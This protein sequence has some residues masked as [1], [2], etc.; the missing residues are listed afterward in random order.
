MLQ[1]AM[2]ASHTMER[3]DT[4]GRIARGYA[5]RSVW[6]LDPAWLVLGVLV[7]LYLS[8]LAFDFRA[9]VPVA[10]IP[11]PLYGWGLVLLVA[12][13]GGAAFG[14]NVNDSPDLQRPTPWREA[15]E[16][17]GWAMLLL[18]VATL[19]GYA[20][21]FYPLLERPY[22]I[23]DVA[24]AGGSVRGELT[25]TP[26]ITSL[27]QCGIAFA[28]G[29]AIRR[30][31]GLRRSAWWEW[32][33]LSV[34]L[35]FALLRTFVWNERLALI[36]LVGAF[37]VAYAAFH[38]FRTAT[39]Y[40][41]ASVVPLLAPLI[42]YLGFALTEYFRSWQFYRDYY[43]SIWSFTFERLATYYAI[44]SNNGIGFLAESQ[45]WPVYS[46]AYV[47]Q[48]AYALP[49]IGPEL[50]AYFGDPTT[51]FMTFLNS[52]AN[53]EFNNP[54]GIFPIVYDIGYVGSA[55]YFLLIGVV[56]G[57]AYAAY[58]RQQL[59]GL[60]IYPVF[61]M[62]LAE[63]MRFNY[64]ASQRVVPALAA[65]ALLY[66]AARRRRIFPAPVFAGSRP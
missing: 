50:Q 9:V 23:T 3:I 52:H 28:I 59:G 14:A 54:S 19:V 12:L 63:L 49:V 46:G 17:P 66:L 42:L 31:S 48:W 25:T 33:A 57:F 18:F 36:E 5:A 35:L 20:V 62:F 15:I 45:Q 56:I 26:G 16:I 13:A 47:L 64:L 4:Y 44:A 65:L 24:M 51:D 8:F 39:A 34:I 7:P 1:P 30:G 37:V 61:V 43:D 6:W 55:L 38:R 58:R 60:L 41:W 32:P 22:L 11:S 10:Y 2:S 21:W 29:C 27:A 40:R 53:P